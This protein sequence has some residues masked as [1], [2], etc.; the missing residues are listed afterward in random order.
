MAR[1][2]DYRY[3]L[4]SPRPVRVGEPATLSVVLVSQCK[5]AQLESCL[6]SLEAH[7]SAYGVE[8]VVVRAGVGQDEGRRWESGHPSIRF[9]LLPTDT[10]R[11]GMRSAG[12]SA[13]AGDVVAFLDDDS[14]YPLDRIAELLSAHRGLRL[15][16]TSERRPPISE[17][18]GERS[19]G[20]TLSPPYVTM[21]AAE[22]PGH[23]DRLRK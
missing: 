19:D 6:D 3:E 17:I 16:P 8:L 14:P 18:A 21:G 23:A 7:C 5:V 12:M 20:R 13:A 4:Q 11:P 22:N 15:F 1:S 10:S 9:V 2:A